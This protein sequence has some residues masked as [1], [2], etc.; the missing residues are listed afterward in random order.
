MADQAL[1]AS[2]E[3]SFALTRDLQSAQPFVI[4]T[5]EKLCSKSAA[6]DELVI[7]EH[8]ALIKLQILGDENKY[9]VSQYFFYVLNESDDGDSPGA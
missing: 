3:A 5:R 6:L 2:Q 7:R 8:K 4:A 1:R 9:F